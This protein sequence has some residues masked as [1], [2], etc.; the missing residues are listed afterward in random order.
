MKPVRNDRLY[1]WI[2]KQT[3]L[4]TACLDRPSFAKHVRD[5][6]AHWELADEAEYVNLMRQRPDELERIV[7]TVAVPETWL[8]RYPESF[9]FLAE[10]LRLQRTTRDSKRLRLLS[11]ACATGEEAYSLA[12]TA[13]YSG[14]PLDQIAVDAIDR[15]PDAILQAQQPTYGSRSVR[16]DL[17][18]WAREWLTS[19]SGRVTVDAGVAETV[20]PRCADILR[21]QPSGLPYDVIFCRNL[22]IYLNDAARQQLVRRL[23]GWLAPDG[24]LF[25]GHA[26]RTEYVS[27]YFQRVESPRAFA[28]KRRSDID[29]ASSS[30][31]EA[32]KNVEVKQR[33]TRLQSLPLN[34][35]SE[36]VAVSTKTLQLDLR[37]FTS[38]ALDAA[39]AENETEASSATEESSVGTP[40]VLE[41]AIALANCGDL[42]GALE[43]A[44]RHV[45]ESKSSVETYQLLGT[46]YAALEDFDEARDAFEKVLYL[47][48]NHEEALLQL[49]M[50][51]GRQGR[52]GKADRYRR[53]AARAHRDKDVETPLPGTDKLP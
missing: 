32:A 50:I 53:R 43:L 36:Q 10:Y 28:W 20:Y 39:T 41:T 44:Q 2:A 3:G 29:A 35:T 21:M 22:L 7:E 42:A 17:P 11:V 47:Q 24:L 51:Y 1:R 12:I 9:A 5:R 25:L 13:A 30:A 27:A 38:P 26:E 52:S 8:F 4:A 45:Q 19:E 49:A 48:P 31:T 18:D 46:L 16:R 40:P 14:W 6:M 37:T 33:A 34:A 23:W 15:Q